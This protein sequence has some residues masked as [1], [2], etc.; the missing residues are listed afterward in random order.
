MQECTICASRVTARS[1]LVCAENVRRNVGGKSKKSVSTGKFVP[2]ASPL[3]QTWYAQKTCAGMWGIMKMRHRLLSFLLVLIMAISVPNTYALAAGESDDLPVLITYGMYADITDHWSRDAVYFLADRYVVLGE[4]DNELLFLPYK[5]VTRGE[6]AYMLAVALGIHM[7]N[8]DEAVLT[9]YYDDLD[10]QAYYAVSVID[11]TMAGVFTLGGD[12]LG[13][14]SLTREEMV[15]YIMKAWQYCVGYEDTGE[16]VSVKFKDDAQ[17][18]TLYAE[19]VARARQYGLI[20]G[21][22]NVFSPNKKASRG[23]AAIVIYRMY[24]QLL[25]ANKYPVENDRQ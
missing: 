13:D 24:L 20:N 25:L 1:N 5:S 22:N 11:L 6:F 15:H 7:E 19:D 14:N 16:I 9:A 17:I 2:R 8:S 4:V 23:D 3:V 18:S 21:K 12:F 10:P